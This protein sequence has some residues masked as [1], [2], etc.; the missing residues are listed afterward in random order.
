MICA[1]LIVLRWKK[2]G[3]ARFRVPGGIVVAV[4]GIAICLV[5]ATQVDLT[6]S[7]ILAATVAAA[8]LNWVWVRWGRQ[9]HE[10][11]TLVGAAR[12]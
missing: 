6:Q 12:Q 1:A 11:G 2:P 4:V 3:A 5:M 10:K 7:R 9:S 8:L